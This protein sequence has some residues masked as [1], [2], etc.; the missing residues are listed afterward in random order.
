MNDEP[1]DVVIAGGGVAAVEALIGLRELAADR[2][3][4]TL[5]SPEAEF[6]LRPMLVAEPFGAGQA[7]RHPLDRIASDFD[8]RLERARVVGV[9]ADDHRVVY[10]S[11]LKRSYDVLILA[12]G[13]RALPVFDDA[14]TFGQPGG[15]PAVRRVLAEIERGDAGRVGFVVP[16]LTGWALPL[17][18]LAL[19]TA[20]SIRAR[21]V[22]AEV[23]LI[24]PEAR[25]LEVFGDRPSATV[26]GLLATA[27][28]EFVGSTTADSR[29]GEL[30]DQAG[31]S[32]R[33]DRVITL[34][35]IRGP[36]IR[37]VPADRDF[38]FIPV[39]RHGRVIGLDDVYAAGD[40]T[41]FPIKQGGLA[42]QQADAVAEHV[43]ARAGA[44]LE[45]AP[46]RPVLRGLL[47]T[48]GEP[49]FLR[50]A[51]ADAPDR[52]ASSLH[53]LWLP[54]TK[55]AGRY[56]GPYLSGGREPQ[57]TDRPTPAFV[58]VEVAP[59]APVPTADRER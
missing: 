53:P 49:R 11:G 6:V 46:F 56:L 52:G 31:S 39:D 30:V 34:P 20:E 33:L 9:D 16:T 47:F 15:G 13:A 25:P 32:L 7:S 2:V 42:T 54:A 44:P 48:G 10:G 21:G 28:V 29:G 50:D 12:P 27:G 23:L 57:A 18:E 17:Y 3:R 59:H 14:I 51:S 40:A 19:M 45:P 36:E 55:I 5:V 38:G 58:D 35:L 8:A 1:P 4:I 24:T 22:S 41:D 37:G 26:E 43:A